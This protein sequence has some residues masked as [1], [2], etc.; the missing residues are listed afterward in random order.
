MRFT[1]E[2][3][4]SLASAPEPARGQRKVDQGEQHG[5]SDSEGQRVFSCK[6]QR[7]P[8]PTAEELTYCGR[9]C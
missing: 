1:A 4:P 3:G 9:R 7:L 6:A 8:M 5:P 2:G